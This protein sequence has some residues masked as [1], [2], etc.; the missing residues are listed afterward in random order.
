MPH[1][2]L[3]RLHVPPGQRSS[4]GAPGTSWSLAQFRATADYDSLVSCGAPVVEGDT[5]RITMCDP[6]PPRFILDGMRLYSVA[7]LDANFNPIDRLKLMQIDAAGS[8][9]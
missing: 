2:P 9:H 8:C 4:W 7:S 1:Q 6:R 5:R 3:R